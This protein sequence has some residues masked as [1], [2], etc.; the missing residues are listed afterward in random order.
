MPE[1]EREKASFS[2]EREDEEAP[3]EKL[4]V[5]SLRD[6]H[7]DAILR[8]RYLDTVNII[9]I[10]ASLP[11]MDARPEYLSFGNVNCCGCRWMRARRRAATWTK[12]R[13]RRL[14]S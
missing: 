12:T 10:R 9:L 8:A 11:V 5:D 7:P 4:L 3:G 2:S 6:L 14:C 13:T 1:S